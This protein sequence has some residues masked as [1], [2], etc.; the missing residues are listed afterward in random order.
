[1]KLINFDDKSCERYRKYLDAYLSNELTVETSLEV[2]SHLERCPHCAD[3]LEAKQSVKDALRFAVNRDEPAP[4]ELRRKILAQLNPQPSRSG[5]NHWWLAAAAMVVLSVG[6]FGT[7]R[8]LIAR[9]TSE[10]SFQAT[11]QATS[12]GLISANNV[13]VF[14]TGMGDHIHCALTVISRPAHEA[15]SECRMIWGL[16]TPAWYRW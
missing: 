14:N 12:N 13:E 4:A 8:W 9:H 15:S 16:T 10:T 6:G 3:E 7:W 5:W 1:M 2:F 11:G